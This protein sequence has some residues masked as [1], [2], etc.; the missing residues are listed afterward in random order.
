MLSI[1]QNDSCWI[2]KGDLNKDTSMLL[3]QKKSELFHT[4]D[5][6]V[7]LDLSAISRTDS[8]GLATLIALLKASNAVNVNIKFVGATQQ[9]HNIAKVGAV[10]QLIHFD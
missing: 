3:W 7:L 6:E 10:E 8:A 2:L 5:K 4:P 9:F 1:E